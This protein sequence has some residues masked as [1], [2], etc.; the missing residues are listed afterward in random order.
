MAAKSER[1][2]QKYRGT[3]F[4][5]ILI[6]DKE[7]NQLRPTTLP[8]ELLIISYGHE[9]SVVHKKMFFEKKKVEPKR[10]DE[11]EREIVWEPNF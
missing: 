9:K 8:Y 3:D 1:E 6:L 10:F 2:R 4:A 11:M 5:S 7:R